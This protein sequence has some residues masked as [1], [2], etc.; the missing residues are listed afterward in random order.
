MVAKGNA[1]L[2]AR[3]EAQ[4]GALE[5]TAS[6]MEQLTAAVRMSADHAN[7]ASAT[8]VSRALGARGSA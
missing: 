7:Q 6:A 4:A 1:D 8:A 5:Q 3:R 2:S